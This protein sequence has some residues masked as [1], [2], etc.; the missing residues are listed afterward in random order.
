MRERRSLLWVTG[1]LPGTLNQ[2]ATAP[3]GLAVAWVPCYP[4][5]QAVY[6]RQDAPKPRRPPHPPRWTVRH[7]AAGRDAR[8]ATVRQR[9]ML[10]C[11]SRAIQLGM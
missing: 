11:A 5:P 6:Q 4:S 8:R 9:R 10:S 1:H 3:G 2:L 7:P